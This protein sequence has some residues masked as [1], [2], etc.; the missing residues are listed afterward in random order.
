ML[1]ELFIKNFILIDELHLSFNDG[2]N[3]FLGETGAGKSINFKGDKQNR[4]K[5]E[6]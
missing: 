5:T 2:F 6:A 1:K 3:V 4:H